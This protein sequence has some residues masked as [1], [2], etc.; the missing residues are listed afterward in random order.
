MSILL[1]VI[2]AAAGS[3]ATLTSAPTVALDAAR[4]RIADVVA[5][6]RLPRSEWDRLAPMVIA[7]L[8]DNAPTLALSRTAVAALVARRAPAMQLARGTGAQ[9][10]QFMIRVRESQN[11]TLGC[12]VLAVPRGAGESVVAADLRPALC[13]DNAP[14]SLRLNREDHRLVAVNALREGTYLG[15]V[16]PPLAFAVR[17]GDGLRLVSRIGPVAV[18]RSVTALQPA[19]PGGKIFVRDPDGQVFAARFQAEGDAQ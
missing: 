16:S 4:I 2:A 7:R 14:A 15:R 12:R 8:P 1:N 18:E 9:T 19:L 10:I 11:P 13:T 17:R 6:H 5:S 3:M